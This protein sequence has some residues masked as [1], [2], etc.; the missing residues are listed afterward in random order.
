MKKFV[1]YFLLLIVFFS[2]ASCSFKKSVFKFK[3]KDIKIALVLAGPI[4]D[5]LWNEA[6]YNGLKRFQT[7]HKSSTKIAVVEKVSPKEAKAVFTRLAEK[8]YDLIIGYGYDSGLILKKI[9]RIYPDTFFCVIGREISREPNLC[10]FNFKDEQYGYLLG[11]VAGVSTFTNKA[12]IVVAKR[13]PSIEKVILGMRKGLRSVNPKA[14]LIVSYINTWDDTTRGREAGIAQVNN[15]VDVITHLADHAGVGII[16][17][18]EE[19]DISAIGAI[20]DQHDLAPSTVITSGL[21]DASQLVYLACEHYIEMILEPIDY[22]YGLKDQVIELAPSYGNIDPT[23]ETRINRIK[24]MLIDLEIAE[25]QEL[26]NMNR[27]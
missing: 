18:A 5:S 19:A 10:S 1:N 23:T 16:R 9:A 7:D 15:G 22:H 11:I 2:V 21:Q 25:I 20:I 3:A 24:S 26:E 8:K 12:G 17:A 6:A 13:L 14:D 27:R 4:N